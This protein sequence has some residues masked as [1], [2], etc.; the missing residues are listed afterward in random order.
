MKKSPAI[1]MGEEFWDYIGIKGVYRE[2]L[3]LFK[4][5]GLEYRHQLKEKFGF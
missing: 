5:I 1:L 4:E 3:Y 2:L